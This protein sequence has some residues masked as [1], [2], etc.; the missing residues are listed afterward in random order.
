MRPK[1][2]LW[3]FRFFFFNRLIS[4]SIDEVVLHFWY[5]GT[6]RQ[7]N[8]TKKEKEKT[9]DPNTQP[10]RHTF[11]A[12]YGNFKW[13]HQRTSHKVL[14]ATELVLERER[15]WVERK[16]NEDREKARKKI[17]KRGFQAFNAVHNKLIFHI[18]FPLNWK[19]KINR[20]KKRNK[21]IQRWKQQPLSKNKTK[22]PTNSENML[23][24]TI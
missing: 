2:L 9:R 5:P 21:N 8:K 23:R 17:N 15:E 20:H 1:I 13:I 3:D 10:H 16:K 19:R 4:I 6:E 24:A 18:D 7:S 14:S 22:T 11:I 12:S